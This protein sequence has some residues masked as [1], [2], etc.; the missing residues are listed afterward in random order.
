MTTSCGATPVSM[1]AA[2]IY[3]TCIFCRVLEWY[4]NYRHQS[5][6]LG[7]A[8]PQFWAV[9]RGGLRRVVGGREILLYAIMYRQWR[10]E[11]G[12]SG[13]DGPGH[14]RGASNEGVFKKSVGK[15]KEIGSNA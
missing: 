3:G 12:A 4:N 15:C 7:V 1:L 6:E 9:G 5:W 13:C 10:A 2:P 14:P 11:E 8:I